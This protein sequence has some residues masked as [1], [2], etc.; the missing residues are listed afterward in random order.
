MENQQT[1]KAA[2]DKFVHAL[3]EWKRLTDALD[4]V[5]VGNIAASV[6]W[7]A[8]VIPA[9]I[10]FD[11]MVR[12]LDFHPVVAGVG[13]L[14]VEFL[15]LATVATTFQLWDYNEEKRK[16]DQNAPVWVA[17]GM[18]AFYL[19]VVLVVNVI[20]DNSDPTHRVA[21][22]LLSSLSIVGAVTLAVRAQHARR[23]A[24]I[25]EERDQRRKE[26]QMKNSGNLPES[27][28][29]DDENLPK[30]TASYSDWR[31][32]PEREKLKMVG[33]SREQL[34]EAYDLTEKTAGNWYRAL[35]KEPGKVGELAREHDRMQTM[36]DEELEE[37]AR[38][39]L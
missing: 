1:K 29:G 6:P 15:G 37:I 39:E 8:P 7:L 36:A 33:L 17:G 22:G 30:V 26:R 13:A 11:H 3:G 25:A 2:V 19:V 24:D 34:Q 21:K 10:A 23:L 16:T 5:L 18:A 31:K 9:S 32:V 38:E 14:V 20:L 12:V 35:R 27:S 4:Q 28:Q